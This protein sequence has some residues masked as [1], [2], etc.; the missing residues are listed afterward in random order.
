VQSGAVSKRYLDD[1]VAISGELEGDPERLLAVLRARND[2][3]LIGFRQRSV[4]TLEGYLRDNGYLDDRPVL[5]ESDLRLRALAS[6]PAN[7]IPDGVAS[8]CLSRWWVWAT[9]MSD[10]SD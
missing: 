6:P 10:G 1:V 5:G 9:K 7:E 3:R 2:H 4:E 8:D